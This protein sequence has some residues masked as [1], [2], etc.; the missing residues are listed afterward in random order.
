M[1]GKVIMERKETKIK[2]QYG[3]CEIKNVIGL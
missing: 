1:M 2:A 3:S